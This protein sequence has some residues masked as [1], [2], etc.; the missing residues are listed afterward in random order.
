MLTLIWCISECLFFSGYLNGWL[1]MKQILTEDGYFIDPCNITFTNSLIEKQHAD[2]LMNQPIRMTHNNTKVKCFYKKVVKV[3]SIEEFALYENRSLQ[4]KDDSNKKNN[5]P[6]NGFDCDEQNK[7]LEFVHIIVLLI[8][9]ISM[10]PLGVLLDT[11]G[12][13]RTRMIAM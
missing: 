8:R 12:S 6:K 9:N 2:I 1:W 5:I 4:S 10:L 7:K 13:S 11:Y 3:V